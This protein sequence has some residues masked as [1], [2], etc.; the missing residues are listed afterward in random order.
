VSPCEFSFRFSF[1]PTPPC[2]QRRSIALQIAGEMR[3][4]LINFTYERKQ[5]LRLIMSPFRANGWG[6]LPSASFS[7]APHCT[8]SGSRGEG[9]AE[10]WGGESRWGRCN[11]P[12]VRGG[13]LIIRCRPWVPASQPC[14]ASRT[15]LGE[16]R[17]GYAVCQAEASPGGP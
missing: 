13:I 2:C 14:G 15:R 6:S 12:L 4:A 1:R 17:V 11:G 10:G 3:R 16:W 8:A 5:H 7:F 9:K